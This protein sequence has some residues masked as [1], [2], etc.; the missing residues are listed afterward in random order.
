MEISAF[1]WV[2]HTYGNFVYVF[3]GYWEQYIGFLLVEPIRFS[4]ASSDNFLRLLVRS[5][6]IGRGCGS[7][8]RF[9]L[10]PTGRTCISVVAHA[11]YLALSLIPA[12]SRGDALWLAVL[13]WHCYF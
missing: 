7:P 3:A 5:D 6:L 4:A 11:A 12:S 2:H 10:S 13:R 1:S 8:G 9:P